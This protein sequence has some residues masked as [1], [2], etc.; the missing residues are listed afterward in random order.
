MA[1]EA[2]CSNPKRQR[3][4]EMVVEAAAKYQTGQQVSAR[5]GAHR[6]GAATT[7]WFPGKIIDVRW[8]ANVKTGWEIDADSLPCGGWVY[9]IDYDDGDVDIALPERYVRK[10]RHAEETSLP[11][12]AEHAEEKAAEGRG[13]NAKAEVVSAPNAAEEK[14]HSA[15]GVEPDD[16]DE[17]EGD[18]GDGGDGIES[19]EG[20]DEHPEEAYDAETDDVFDNSDDDLLPPMEK[21]A[22]V[23]AG[24]ATPTVERAS[25]KDAEQAA[26]KEPPTEAV[27][28]AEAA[29]KL[30]KAQGV[31]SSSPPL[32]SPIPVRAA[33]RTAHPV[34]PVS[35]GA[36]KVVQSIEG[37]PDV[38]VASSLVVT[39]SPTHKKKGPVS[40]VPIGRPAIAPTPPREAPR[41]KPPPNISSCFP[42]AAL[43][44]STA[45]RA[46]TL[47]GS[48][49]D[50]AGWAC[51]SRIANTPPAM[52]RPSNEHDYSA[53]SRPD[54]PHCPHAGGGARHAARRRL[55]SLMLERDEA[56]RALSTAQ[57]TRDEL[58]NK[59]AA[60]MR[61][62]EDE[63]SANVRLAKA[64]A[65]AAYMRIAEFYGETTQHGA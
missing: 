29:P 58:L 21:A 37:T 15:P 45:A 28:M 30:A 46:L 18:E 40:F 43:A 14:V 6:H 11:Y 39:P 55:A 57:S 27:V 62:I 1:E 59:A 60:C 35:T 24:L 33:L 44:D 16:E 31:P 50:A 56:E 12:R 51:G 4:V 36:D 42:R 54:H 41:D 23:T 17:Y 13:R 48:T 20:D 34:T 49:G 64:R 61:V 26:A 53:P 9:R 65:E 63:T 3:V 38:R 2:I 52:L 7:F 25:T 5:F 8:D 32:L 22:G 10:R 19:N 47:F